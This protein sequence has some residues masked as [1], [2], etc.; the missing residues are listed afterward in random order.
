[1]RPA[2]VLAVLAMVALLF[3][4]HRRE[5]AA[6]L[7]TAETKRYALFF[8]LM[9]IGI[10]FAYHRGLAFERVLLGYTINVIFFV[11][12]VSQVTSLQRLRSFL[13]VIC[14][15][16]MVYSIFGGLLQADRFGG[17]RFAVTGGVFDPND[18]AYVLLSLS[19]L[20]L[21]FVQFNAGLVKRLVARSE[22]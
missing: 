17:A 13:W 2:L 18:T 10:P 8:A 14:L 9:I 20:C 19:P 1:M 16:T 6:A 3:G 12:L 5:L 11:L 15:S 22:E 21:Y 4:G 7:S